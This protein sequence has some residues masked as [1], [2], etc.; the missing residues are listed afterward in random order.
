MTTPD[1][2]APPEGPSWIE[3]HPGVALTFVLVAVMVTLDI[4]AGVGFRLVAG[5]SYFIR[6]QRIGWTEYLERERLYRVHN[7]LYDHDLAPLTSVDNV[8]WGPLVYRVDTNSLGFKD[9]RPRTVSLEADRP[10]VLLIGDSFT[11]GVGYS[12]AQTFAG[13]LD[14]TLARQGVEVLNA[15]VA[16]Y[17]PSI[18]ARKIEYLLDDLGLEVDEVVVF[19]DISDAQDEAGVYRRLADGRIVTQSEFTG[20]GLPAPEPAREP[21]AFGSLKAALRENTIVLATILQAKD[22]IAAQAGE[23]DSFPV[24][25]DRSLWTIDS[26]VYEDYGREGVARM[27]ESMTRLHELLGRHEVALTVAVYPWPDQVAAADL[28]SRQVQIW[29]RWS[30]ERGVR[31]VN[32]FPAFIAGEA[33]ADPMV[34]LRRYYINGDYH[35][36]EAGHRLV[37]RTFLQQYTPPVHAEPTR[38]ADP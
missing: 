35:W 18:Y 7:P 14:S 20:F 26:T 28:D 36:N 2:E 15:G 23:S 19:I 34:T 29:Q 32:L 3:R 10:R 16:S 22:R 1:T 38:A 4:A 17:A 21:G 6:P 25:N 12:Y 27:E 33:N 30:E 13:L 5:Y 37:A 31:F 11:E 9:S 24:N 8:T